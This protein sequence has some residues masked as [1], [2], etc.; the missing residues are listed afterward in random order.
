MENSYGSMPSFILF[1]GL[2]VYTVLS[3]YFS[4]QVWNNLFNLTPL[5]VVGELLAL[6]KSLAVVQCSPKE[7]DGVM[8]FCL[9]NPIHFKGAF[10]LSPYYTWTNLH[11]LI[12]NACR[13]HEGRP[14]SLRPQRNKLNWKGLPFWRQSICKSSRFFNVAD[15]H[16]HST[17]LY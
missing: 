12:K 8:D 10:L 11:S 2:P 17:C 16:K 9:D 3:I 7:T 5:H 14:D 1:I 6:C 13:E 15:S 4:V